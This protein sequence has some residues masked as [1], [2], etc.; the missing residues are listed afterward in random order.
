V[1]AP[2]P[3]ALIPHS[4]ASVSAVSYI[5]YQLSAVLSS[6]ERL[7]TAGRET[8]PWNISQMV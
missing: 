5:M 2:V 7:G 3:A 8:E 6:G 4:M 1:Q